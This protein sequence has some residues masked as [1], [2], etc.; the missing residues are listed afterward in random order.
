MTSTDT[1]ASPRS[2]RLVSH[3]GVRHVT[4]GS[5][6]RRADDIFA[7][8]TPRIPARHV[9]ITVTLVDYSRRNYKFRQ[10]DVVAGESLRDVV[11]KARLA[12]GTG[13]LVFFRRASNGE[14]HHAAESRQ[15]TATQEFFAQ[16]VATDSVNAVFYPVYHMLTDTAGRLR[17][18]LP[19]MLASTLAD[20]RLL[21]GVS[22]L[23]RSYLEGLD[24]LAATGRKR[25]LGLVPLPQAVAAS[26]ELLCP[27]VVVHPALRP[28]DLVNWHRVESAVSGSGLSSVIKCAVVRTYL[29]SGFAAAE[30]LEL[31]T[32]IAHTEVCPIDLERLW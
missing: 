28:G 17:F 27:T 8:P 30:V 18:A 10:F 7:T 16:E 12:W 25:R 13:P 5:A 20:A 22:K 3:S 6:A 21:P 23:H 15:L 32:D 26:G 19:P 24:A 31:G 1:W 14:A 9:R 11:A 2:S 4:A 29:H